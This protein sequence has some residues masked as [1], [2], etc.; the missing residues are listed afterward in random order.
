MA[1]ETYDD[2][3]VG[4][5]RNDDKKA[6]QD[7]VEERKKLA[8]KENE[9]VRWL[10]IVVFVVLL[11][12]AALVSVG[13][14]VLLR[15]DQKD[16]FEHDYQ[17]N[18]L[19]I[20]ES[21]HQSVERYLEALDSLSIAYTNHAFVT[22]SVFPNVTL[23]D[24]E[25]RGAN[26][27]ILGGAP[28]INFYPLITDE[29]R[30]GWE[31]YVGETIGHY[32]QCMDAD[33]EQRLIQD[34]ILGLDYQVVE[35][36]DP[37]PLPLT[38][39]DIQADGS[40]PPA[41]PGAGP[42]LPIWQMTPAIPLHS[43]LLVNLLTH[44]SGKG[45]YNATVNTAQA[46]IEFASN[47]NEE[48]LGQTGFAYQ[49]FLSHGQFRADFDEFIGDPTSSVGY[50]VFDSFNVKTRKVVGIL[51]TNFYWILYFK[52]I[53]PSNARGIIC[54]IEN[55]HNQSFS[56]RIDGREAVYLGD[57]DLHD[58][59]FDYLEVSAD[60]TEYITQKK[61]P[62]TRSYTSVDLNG[63]YSRYFLRVYPSQETEDQFIDNQPVLMLVLV[64]CVFAFTSFVFVV[65]DWVIARRQRIV[66]ERA[67]ASGAIVSSLFPSTVRDQIYEETTKKHIK[68]PEQSNWKLQTIR[69]SQASNGDGG[70]DGPSQDNRHIAQVYQETTIM[71]ADLAGFTQWSSTR[72][73]TEVFDLLEAIY[74]EFD[75]LAKKKKVFKVETVGDCYV[76]VTGIP[77][78][79]ED[80][81]VIMAK[82]A[83]SCMQKMDEVTSSLVDK[84][85]ADTTDLKLRG[86]LHSGPVTGGVLRGEKGRFQLF[87]DTMNTA[88][89]MESNGLKGRIQ[90]SRSTFDCLT[91][92]GK[93]TWLTPREGKVH[94]KGKGEMQTYWLQLPTT[95]MET[96]STVSSDYGFAKKIGESAHKDESTTQSSPD[97]T[98]SS[99]SAANQVSVDV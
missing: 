26:T 59:K 88:S 81:A 82:F 13:V 86:G 3:S 28:V 95:G 63:D 21:F 71:F 12:T 70:T 58:T 72:T 44:P 69:E 1:M 47:L 91:A 51:A 99:E 53:L 15:K 16:D 62:Q 57:G 37:S 33:T 27:R 94:A 93:S 54:V 78:P 39:K 92:K 24:F 87:G 43:V 10:R 50:P 76:A 19:K 56:Y 46:V 14:Y 52:D 7:L 22:G 97:Q 84:L 9:A 45:A 32:P 80:H 4:S 65:Y 98:N 74:N 73:P 6:N 20:I 2:E 83:N 75:H 55:N 96:M 5:H 11:V 34:A 66:M 38:I 23:P 79:Q 41:E 90:V 68:K 64:I 25:V 60:I 85:G 67:L 48:H 30:P 31:A 29:T 61:G 49:L 42:Y 18:A 40:T 77:L 17:A 8:Q 35:F 36:E 89:R